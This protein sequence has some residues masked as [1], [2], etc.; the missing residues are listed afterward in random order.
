[1]RPRHALAL[2]SVVAVHGALLLLYYGPEQKPLFGDE[3]RYWGLA[4]R[5]FEGQ[6]L[7]LPLLWPPFYVH[8][9]TALLRLTGGSLLAVQALQLAL[10]LLVAVAARDLCIRLHG[11]RRVGDLVAWLTLAYP[12]LVAFTHY[13]WPEV[14]HLALW[15][16]SAWIVVARRT[17]WAWLALLGLLLGLALLT[18]NLL[19]P[20]LPVL[21]L[22]LVLQG[23]WRERVLRVALV[24]GVLLVT[25]APTLQANRERAGRPVIANSLWFNLWV[26]LKDTSRK[27]F[28]DSIVADEYIAYRS[29]ARSFP[30]RTR[31]LQRKI[32]ALLDE[33]GVATVAR[34]QLTRQYFRLFDKDS[35][36]TDLL[37]GGVS[38]RD[39][40]GYRDPPPLLAGAVRIA[41]YGLWGGVLVGAAIGLALFTTRSRPGL[42]PAVA[43]LLYNLALFGLLHVKTRYRLQFLPILFFYA[44]AALDAWL[45][46]RGGAPG[47]FFP[48]PWRA[49]AAATGAA[50]L[51]L[52]AFGRTW[53]PG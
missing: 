15:M 7:P 25:V 51:L 28:V 1:M 40:Q 43:F 30:E 37:P 29:S 4:Q 8:F 23:R 36:L 24:T 20:F 27:D 14:L 42:W 11:S 3:V 35:V 18:K 17:S 31:V 5:A 2:A 46:R 50:L 33:R 16:S 19:Q 32:A 49:P 9:L 47:P 52:L 6:P 12:P 44:A 39:G 21:L 26:G 10:L 53:V 22:P 38:A 34:D 48:D 13:L 41:S 45:A